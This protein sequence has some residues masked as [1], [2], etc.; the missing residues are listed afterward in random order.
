[1]PR[2]P[3]VAARIPEPLREA[4]H[5]RA[6]AEDVALGAVIREALAAYLIDDDQGAPVPA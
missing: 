3:V 5:E 1:M 6:R 2:D 4:L